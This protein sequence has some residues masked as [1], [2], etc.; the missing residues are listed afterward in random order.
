MRLLIVDDEPVIRKGL[1]K[2]LEAYDLAFTEIQIAENGVEALVKIEASSPDIV[3]TD[4]NMPK[5]D[6]LELCKA[7]NEQYSHIQTVVISGYSD[8]EYAQKCIRYGV[9]HYLLKPITITDLFEVLD[10]LIK[11]TMQGYIPVSR[12]VEWISRM[13]NCIWS[14]QTNELQQLLSQWREYCL[15][16]NMNP[17]QMKELFSDC[18]ETLLYR[19]KEHNY[20]PPAPTAFQFV[21]LKEGLNQFECKLIGIFDHLSATRTGQYKDPMEEARNYIDSRLAQEITLDEVAGMIGLTPTYFSAVFK[22]ITGQTFV[23]Y[24]I[25]KRMEKAKD[26]L[27]IPHIRIIDVAVE[28]GYDDYPHFTKTFKK[29]YGITPSEYRSGLGI[30]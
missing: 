10:I 26:L 15:A 24:R 12:Y 14:L 13:E 19:L 11:T 18:M 28:V 5:M 25:H 2:M 8:F 16:T 21:G 9:K 6:G 29:S 7:I 23:R 20:S 30:R 1:L 4:I 3:L 27:A 17:A 22:K